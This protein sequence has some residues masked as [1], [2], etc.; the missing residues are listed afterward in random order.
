MY[1]ITIYKFPP[2]LTAESEFSVGNRK[3]KEKGE[4]KNKEAEKRKEE[5]KKTLSLRHHM[6]TYNE[7]VEQTRESRLPITEAR[8]GIY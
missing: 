5:R 8:G 7:K 6:L 3:K 2:H 1:R 4:V